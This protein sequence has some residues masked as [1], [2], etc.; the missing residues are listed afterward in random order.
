MA[1]FLDDLSLYNAKAALA[2]SQA[3]AKGETDKASMMNG[4]K[5]TANDTSLS[6]TDRLDALTALINIGAL[7]DV[8]LP[9]YFPVTLTY[10]NTQSYTGVHNDLNGLQGGTAGEYYHLTQ[11]QVTKV[12]NAAVLGDITWANIQGTYTS[13]AGLVAALN[14]K[15]NLLSGTGFVKISG[16]TI[17]YDNTSYLSTITGI[18]AGGELTGTY[19]NP[20]IS[21]AAVIGK[22][23]TGWNGSAAPAAISSADSILTGLQKLN[24]N[25][26]YAIANPTGVSSVS[27]TNNAASVFTTTTSPQTG[28]AVVNVGLNTQNANL[29]LAS[30]SSANGTVPAF[31]A[32]VSADLPLSGATP[33]SYGSPTLIPVL[34]VDASGRI[35]SIS[36]I[37]STSGGQVNSV[38]MTVPAGGVFNAV[39]TGTAVDPI[40]G[41]TLGTQTANTVWAG[42]TTGAAATPGFRSL[43][44]ADIGFNFPISQ[45]D[46]LQ[47]ALD[48]Y[49]TDSLAVN[50]IFMGN[51]SSAA[52]NSEV[53][54]D[55]TATFAIVSGTNQAQ[56][57][58]ANGAVTYPKIQD[59]QA[60]TVL[61]RYALTNGQVQELYF[62]ASDFA[63][64][65]ST[66]EIGLTSPNTPILTSK[67]D[68]LTHTGTALARL[69]IGA[70]A[71]FL[72]ADTAATT[73]NK[74]VAMSGDATISVSGAVTIANSAVTLAKMANLAANT[75]IGNNTGSPAAPI[76]LTQAQLTAMIN[77][78]T[79]AL[80]GVVPASGGGTVNFLRADGSWAQPTG[81]GTINPAVR[82][83]IPYY[84]DAPSGIAL[85]GLV[86]QTTNGIYFL[87]ANVTANA[88]VAPDW[89]GST[90]TGNVVLATSPSL[91]TPSLGVATAT[92]INGLT[93]TGTTGTLTLANGSTLATAGAFST[94][95]TATGATNVTLPTTGTL[96]TLAGTETLSNKTLLSPFIGD[97]ATNGHAHFR[98]AAGSSPAGQNQYITMFFQEQA[99]VKRMSLI[100][101]LDAFQSELAFSATSTQRYTFPNA[102]GTV[103]LIDSTQTLTIPAGGGNSGELTLGG[104]TSGSVSLQAP[105]SVT[106]AGVYTLP[107][108]YPTGANQF[109]TAT[110]GG[111]MSWTTI[112]TGGDVVGPSSSV[113]GNFAVFSGTTG[114]LIAEPAAASLTAAGRATFNDGVNVGVSGPTGTTGTIIFRNSANAFTTT[115]QAS[116]SASANASYFWPQAPGTT[117]QILST[118]GSGNLSWT[119]A[120]TG[121]VTTGGTQTFTGLNTFNS[122]TIRMAGSSSGTTTLNASAAAGTTTVTLPALT[123]TVALLENAQTFSGAKTFSAQ[124]TFTS[125]PASATSVSISPTTG[126][127]TNAQLTIGGG[128]I[129]WMSFDGSANGNPTFTTRSIGTKIVLFPFLSSATLDWAIGTTGGPGPL[130]LTSPNTI[131]FFANSGGGS[132]TPISAGQF[133]YN[134]TARGLN[135]TAATDTNRTIPQLLISGAGSTSFMSFDSSVNG[136]PI[137]A[138]AGGIQR[139]AGTRIIIYPYQGTTTLDWA[140]GWTGGPG[141][142]WFTSPAGFAFYAN[143]GGGSGTPVISLTITH[144]VT[145]IL[146]ELRLTTGVTATQIRNNT[147][148]SFIASGC[149]SNGVGNTNF[150]T[151]SP[152]GPTYN[153]RS[154]GTRFIL[155]STLNQF[156]T[157][158]AIGVE[159]TN[160]GTT[161]SGMWL[162]VQNTSQYFKFMAQSTIYAQLDGTGVLN[163]AQS[164]GRLQI[165]G[166]Q[167]VGSRITG[168]GAPT[169][170]I[171]RAAFT[172]TASTNYVQAE[173]TATIEALKAVIT[174]LRTHGLINN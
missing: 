111:V 138:T 100:F 38:V 35:T 53:A 41:F 109:L 118:D 93:I 169:G 97:S 34:T 78:F 143:S 156:N 28:V 47:D 129:Q 22:V 72:M 79:S 40:V 101:D 151:A 84:S 14:A 166:T 45:I 157:D 77:Q 170:T 128:T 108:A 70:N 23:L 126:S 82:Y 81:T 148:T 91:T 94:T 42:P 116:T 32:I 146:N 33:G 74:W 49:L 159:G 112:T 174:D 102:T 173:L 3:T 62:N 134:S 13:N 66:G 130:W 11:A 150:A 19:P 65:S 20:G 55:L 167:V 114:K 161:T 103:A 51:T 85:S 68:L 131:V 95:L 136:N 29:F 73:G 37:A 8:A 127:L 119:A 124:A 163:L 90:G 135:L 133:Q 92:S 107:N 48:G 4:L 137:F 87:R 26:N 158:Y 67:G 31:R 10:E 132:G 36:T 105:A 155:H 104:S 121:N 21:N 149:I 52:V 120:G 60:Q 106:G 113:D 5:A 56:F 160:D 88:A 58:I 64:N 86:P 83:S 39:N 164:T 16:T 145:S 89:I 27:L 141:N 140:I 75:V 15:Q 18:N 154:L 54:G 123:G 25:L 30:S 147:T 71:T 9:P 139:S 142:M 117:G 110:T 144:S 24:A 153:T 125:S 152:I 43:V 46:G 76:A 57:T 99:G 61:G 17:S 7:L 80:S 63:I 44:L 1:T 162:S 98:K 59:V 69:P 168:W 12:N 2:I 50:T 172:T 122:G 165:N 171:S 6:N 96:A 115:I